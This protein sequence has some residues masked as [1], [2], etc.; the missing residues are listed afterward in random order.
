MDGGGDGERETYHILHRRSGCS[1]RSAAA[2][3][4]EGNGPGYDADHDN[5]NLDLRS[6]PM[7]PANQR[8]F[9]LIELVVVIVILGIL[10]AFAVP[11]FM[12]LED[13]ARAASVQSMAGSL[14]SADS[15]A[16][17]LWEANGTSPA[18]LTVD[19]KRIT[20]TNGYPNAATVY[21]LLQDTSGFAAAGLG[22]GKFDVNGDPSGKCWVQ[23]NS[24]TVN[25]GAVIPPTLTYSG[26]ATLTNSNC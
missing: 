14:L 15:M 17:G 20:F 10:A 13:Q 24:A 1:S 21:L 7:I 6:V 19:G 22:T 16:H 18:T 26:G 23:Y 3:Q 9:T 25:A 11:K 12:G 2:L 8:G 5:N 4:H